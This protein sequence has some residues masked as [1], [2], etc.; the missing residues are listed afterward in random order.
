MQLGSRYGHTKDIE[1]I[2]FMEKFPVDIRHN[3]KIDRKKIERLVNVGK[4]K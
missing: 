3:I 2:Y 4:I 1:N